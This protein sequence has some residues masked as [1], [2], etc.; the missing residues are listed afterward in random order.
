MSFDL[1]RAGMGFLFSIYL[2]SSHYFFYPSQPSNQETAESP[3]K[4]GFDG[5]LCFS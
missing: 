5:N 2:L 3:V 1:W 4:I